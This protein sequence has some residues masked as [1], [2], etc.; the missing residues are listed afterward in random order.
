MADIILNNEK[1]NQGRL[2][3]KHLLGKKFLMGKDD[4]Y[5]MLMR[6]YKDNLNIELT[7]YARADD[8]WLYDDVDHYVEKYKREGFYLIDEPN[9][10][11]LRPFDVFLIAIPDPR[12]MDKTVTNHCAIYLGDGEVIH[13]RYGTLSNVVPYRTVLRNLTTH[14]IRH[15]LVPDLRETKLN[16]IDVLDRM[17]P[18]K[19][20]LIL[21]AINDQANK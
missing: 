21:G 4:C 1:L 18:H 13:H 14:V 5:S 8:W 6:M 9:L 17:L 2:R 7:N 19:R 11:D 3:Y 20:E 10:E 12:K 15:K 16:N